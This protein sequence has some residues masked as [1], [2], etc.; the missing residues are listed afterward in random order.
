MPDDLSISNLLSLL[1]VDRQHAAIKLCTQAE[2]L[3]RRRHY[4]EAIRVADSAAQMAHN[5]YSLIGITL[6]YLS[7][8]R[9]AS[10]VPHEEALAI[11]DCDRAI[12]SL[13]VTPFNQAIANLIRAQIEV[14][15]P[16][17]EHRSILVYL[18]RAD[19]I[20]ERLIKTERE[21]HRLNQL[22]FYK[23]LRQN[24]AKKIDEVSSKLVEV[25][26]IVIPPKIGMPAAPPSR[27]PIGPPPAH[28]AP[29][30]F[31]LPIPTRLVWPVP[32]PAINL[33]LHPIAGGVVPDVDIT[34]MIIQH[35][36]YR[37][38]PLDMAAVAPSPFHL[39]AR[40]SYTVV[41]LF[42]N[43]QGQA[44]LVRQQP[45]LERDR[46][47]VA[48]YDPVTRAAWIDEAESTAPYTRVHIIGI[49]R[50]WVEDPAV[51]PIILGNPRIIGIVEALLT[52]A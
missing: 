16:N 45:R 9:L 35:R 14:R 10:H 38:E 50:D 23:E 33:E 4:A 24:I 25:P 26:L 21:H 29:P 32:Q 36:P 42:D 5:D 20:L 17:D 1:Q 49:G 43:T 22:D 28:A 31:R 7:H 19:K 13:S 3:R 39:Q 2:G 51:D 47:L 40:A 15:H 6:L 44:V 48:L 41:P 34:Q 12:R 30:P 37:V 11:R 8:M 18:D 46:Q 27:A 52:P